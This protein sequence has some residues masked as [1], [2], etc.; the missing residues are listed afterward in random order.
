M[1][2]FQLILFSVAFVAVHAQSPVVWRQWRMA[3]GLYESYSPGITTSPDGTAWITHGVSV[4]SVLDGYRV[5]H[6]TG[7]PQTTRVFGEP[8]NWAW[9]ASRDGISLFHGLQWTLR[10]LAELKDYVAARSSGAGKA[11]VL[12][13]RQLFEYDFV[14]NSLRQLWTNENARIGALTELAGEPGNGLW[15][16][17]R[18]GIG[19]LRQSEG[20]PGT[21]EWTQFRDWPFEL[22]HF[23]YLS[24]GTDGELFATATIE[25][26]ENENQVVLHYNGKQWKILRRTRNDVSRAWRGFD[27]TVWIK[28]GTSL[29]SQQG[30]RIEK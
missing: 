8:G 15:I 24:P 22:S 27:D 29:Y 18:N 21:W 14:R 3:D 9:T 12:T 26:A 10:P 11:L 1:G 5:R 23:R 30:G 7:V 4:A 19:R 20:T 2:R 6:V 28:D 17:G 16:A 13:T 25:N